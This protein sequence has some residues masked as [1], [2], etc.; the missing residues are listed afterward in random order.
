MISLAKN[1]FFSLLKILISYE[2]KNRRKS[3]LFLFNLA[4]LRYLPSN[5][6]INVV[7]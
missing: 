3:D 1:K 4:A 6:D 5:F 2:N 7:F